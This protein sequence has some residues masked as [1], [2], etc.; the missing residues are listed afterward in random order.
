MGVSAASDRDE[1][2][3]GVSDRAF[4]AQFHNIH[5]QHSSGVELFCVCGGW[6]AAV[7]RGAGGARCLLVDFV[8]DVSKEDFS[9]DLSWN[10][11]RT[12]KDKL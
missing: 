5:V 9:A 1:F 2:D 12:P 3:G 7:F 6:V 4:V 8:L 10:S 11:L